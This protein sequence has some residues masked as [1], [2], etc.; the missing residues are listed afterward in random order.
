MCGCLL[1][2]PPHWGPGLQLRHVP[3]LGIELETLWFAGRCTI[4]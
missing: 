3:G 2:A 4:H 1:W